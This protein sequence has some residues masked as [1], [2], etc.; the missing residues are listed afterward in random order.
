M[1]AAICLLRMAGSVVQ[2][3]RGDLRGS[4]AD[5]RTIEFAPVTVRWESDAALAAE[6]PRIRLEAFMRDVYGEDA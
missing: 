2:V 5:G 1:K 3:D 4:Q 6:Y